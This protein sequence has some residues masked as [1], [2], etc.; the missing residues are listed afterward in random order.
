MRVQTTV[1]QSLRAR[2]APEYQQTTGILKVPWSLHELMSD[3]I[4]VQMLNLQ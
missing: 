4:D 2:D 3:C 1:V